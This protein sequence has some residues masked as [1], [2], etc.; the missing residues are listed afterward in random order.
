MS[1]DPD[2]PSSSRQEHPRRTLAGAYRGFVA[3]G[4]LNFLAFFVMS[5]VIGAT[6]FHYIALVGVGLLAVVIALAAW[7]Y[8][9]WGRPGFAAGLLGGYALMTIISGGTCTLFVSNSLDSRFNIITGPLLYIGA[10]V[11]FGLV[12]LIRR[13]SQSGWM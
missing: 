10:V 1:S 4:V 12:L 7:A 11:I 3:F 2:T 13:L 8:F 5:N 6:G 9:G